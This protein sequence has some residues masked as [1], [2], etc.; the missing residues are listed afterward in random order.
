MSTSTIV[1][2]VN[3]T[4]LIPVCRIMTAGPPRASLLSNN[5]TH[6]VN[7]SH[8]SEEIS[9]TMLVTIPYLQPT[10]AR[11]IRRTTDNNFHTFRYLGYI[12]WTVN[13][14]WIKDVDGNPRRIAH[15]KGSITFRLPL[16][17]TR[18]RM[19]YQ[20][21]LGTPSYALNVS[22]VI[23]EHSELGSQLQAVMGG[24]PRELQRLLSGRKLSIYSLFK[25][26]FG[27]MNLFFV[28]IPF[29]RFAAHAH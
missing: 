26:R 7:E 21:G 20:C 5:T 2:Y 8:R 4:K 27:E 1:A 13:D 10:V 22:H 11:N 3:A 29:T 16:T 24:S 28:R 23:E 17:S 9:N 12:T 6:Q 19:H 15:R 14:S 25:T 18:L